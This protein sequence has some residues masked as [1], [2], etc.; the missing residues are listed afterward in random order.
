[1]AN[2]AESR[3]TLARLRRGIGKMPGDLPDLWEVTL[4]G[5]PENF[6]S[7]TGQPSLQ[8]WAVYSALTLFALHQ[9]GKDMGTQL[10]HKEGVSIGAAMSQLV[11]N[12]D[13]R[14]RIKRRLDTL[15]TSTTP[16]ELA[17]HLRGIIQLLKAS[18]KPLDYGM[19][20]KDL[21]TLQLPGREGEVHLRW[22]QDFYRM[23][24][25]NTDNEKERN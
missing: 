7:K 6:Y 12:D 17:N 23:N 2:E 11:G 5:L 9:Q 25:M 13:D 3:A 19:L 16:Q 14:E 15:V 1:M 18:D 22:G 24:D 4:D 21:F 20:A 8:E 10:M